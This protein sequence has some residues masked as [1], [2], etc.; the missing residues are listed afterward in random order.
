[1]KANLLATK[2]IDS[3]RIRITFSGQDPSGGQKVIFRF[4]LLAVYG[5]KTKSILFNNSKPKKHFF[6]V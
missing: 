2:P 4:L 6:V 1:M 5:A 3:A